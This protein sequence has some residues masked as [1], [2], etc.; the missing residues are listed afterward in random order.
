LPAWCPEDV[1]ETGVIDVVDL[2]MGKVRD[3]GRL[4][5]LRQQAHRWRYNAPSTTG[6]LLTVLLTVGR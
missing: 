1:D 5:P 3:I 4:P 2:R 6:R